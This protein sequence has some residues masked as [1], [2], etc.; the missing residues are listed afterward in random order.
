[1]ELFKDKFLKLIYMMYSRYKKILLV[2]DY[3]F[4]LGR[5]TKFA[6]VVRNMISS[7]GLSIR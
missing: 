6:T 2:G 5:N 4:D 7:Y 3:N 1:M